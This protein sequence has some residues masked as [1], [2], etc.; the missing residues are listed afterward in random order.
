MLG[1]I[2]LV[3]VRTKKE[4]DGECSGYE[5]MKRKGRI[6]GAI[7]HGGNMSCNSCQVK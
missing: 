2:Q 1:D 6:P 3:D 7:Y 5:Y 4:Y